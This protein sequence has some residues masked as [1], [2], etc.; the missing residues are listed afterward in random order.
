[1]KTQFKYIFLVVFL[2]AFSNTFARKVITGHLIESESKNPVESAKID[3]LL[4]P[5][6]MNV[7]QALTNTEG[8]FTLFKADS[9]KTYCL[10][11]SKSFFKTRIVPVKLTVPGRIVNMGNT[12]MEP[13]SITI[14]EITVS[15]SKIKVTELA[16][17]TVYGISAD[18]KKT[19]TDGLDVLRKVPTVQVDYFNEDIK[20][21]GKS[22]IKIEV[23]GIS[24]DKNYIK[25]LHPT[26][27]DKMEVITNPTGKYDADVDAVINIITNKEMAY[28]LKGMVNVMALPNSMDNYMGR[29]SANLDYGLK[30]ISYYV[31]ANGGTGKFDYVSSMI[32][33]SGINSVLR[34]GDS[35]I[36]FNDMNF[37]G[38]FNYDPNEV[39]TLSLNLSYNG[40][41]NK[42]NGFQSNDILLNDVLTGIN[43]TENNSLSG[44]N[45]LNSS[46]FYKHK[47][48][49]KKN[50][51]LEIE[52]SFY[53]SLRSNSTS[54]YQN[55]F[56]DKDSV[57][58]SRS[59]MQ[60]EE[61]NTRN[62]SANIRVNYTLPFDS[63][64][65][66]NTGISSNYGYNYVNN[67]STRTYTPDMEYINF[68]SSFYAELSKTLKKGSFKVGS[69][70]ELSDVT[71]NT[72][73]KNTYFSLL[74]YANGQY[75][76]NDKN[77]L[78]LNYSRRVYRPSNGQLNPFV[79]Y[80]DS[81]TETH[82]NINLVPAYRDNAQLTYTL[83][84]GENK[85]SGNISP[86]LF[87]EYRNGLIQYITQQKTN[88]NIFERVPVNLSNGYETGASLSLYAQIYTVI[89]N[90][91]FR[92]SKVHIDKYLDQISAIDRDN[93]SLNAQLMCPLPK[94][95]RL[96]VVFNI[97]GP[98]LNGQELT[99]NA[100][101]NIIGISK[102]FKN[103][104]SLTI[105]A[106]NP[107]ASQ[108]FY[109]TSTIENGTL[110]QRTESYM[111]FRNAFVINYSIN[112]KV[113]KDINSQKF[114]P[115][116][117]QEENNFKLPF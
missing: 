9:T 99:Q 45:G 31:S 60:T 59:P 5:D 7:E 85:F 25:K 29:G 50:H 4:L 80:S 81:L 47:F 64:Y 16:D 32:R 98:S 74:P 43:R 11:V 94:D 93:W 83:K 68:K 39:N 115:E 19:S 66:F 61:N 8:L 95:F 86:Q 109:N 48:D 12:E 89:F 114:N 22:N 44:N 37:S 34:S 55:F 38:G 77:S 92:Y 105:M 73:N 15:G 14:K 62:S 53:S 41:S 101:F 111:N 21:E 102:Q 79:S 10:K 27:I 1:M 116:Q 6:S 63:V 113:G 2:L 56:F 30:K 71:I 87:F 17:R 88:S 106:F 107:F 40:N 36:N 97:N 57:E 33:N 110:Y 76:F 108:N 51:A 90:S 104:S 91:N 26:Q 28:G 70:L 69:R 103:N 96:F 35:R 100:P 78:K 3:L 72:T 13:S 42:S 49:K 18:M 52:T 58:L 23:D 82:G 67:I 24:R 75:K 112:F 117:T 65:N 46:L 20:V 54:N 84:F